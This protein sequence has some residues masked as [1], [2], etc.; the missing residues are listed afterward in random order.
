MWRGVVAAVKEWPNGRWIALG[1]VIVGAVFVAIEVAVG[2]SASKVF[3][4]GAGTA[5]AFMLVAGTFQRFWGGDKLDE[6]KMG[7]MSLSFFGTTKRALGQLNDRVTN[8]METI[9]DRLYDLEKAVF[10]DGKDDPEE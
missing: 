8:Q 2:A 10:K 6:A 3:F 1:G 9:N 4:T 5:F 7:G